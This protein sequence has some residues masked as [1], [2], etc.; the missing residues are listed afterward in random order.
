MNGVI[1]GALM[2]LSMVQ[3][4]TDTV[5]PVKDAKTLAVSTDG[6]SIV[7]TGWDRS[8]VRVQASH[9]LRTNVTVTRSHGGERIDVEAAARRGP[10]GIVDYQISVP[11]TLG[12][13]LDG[14]YTDISVDGVSGSVDAETL[15]GDVTIK[16]G[17]GSVKASTT[18][19]KLLVQGAQGKIDAE[20]AA[21]EIRFLDVVGDVVAESAGGDI[22]FENAKAASVDVGT[23]GGRIR[24]DGS[25][26]KTGTYLFGSYGGPVTLVLPEGTAASMSLS[27][28][29]GSVLNNFSG[30][31]ERL[32]GGERHKVDL[33]GGGAVVEVE[34]FGG[35]IAIVKKGTEGTVG[36]GEDEELRGLDDWVSVVAADQA[37]R[38]AGFGATLGEEL[39]ERIRVHLDHHLAPD[40]RWRPRVGRDTVPATIPR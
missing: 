8:D 29:H 7:V 20:T 31:M 14:M 33:N 27:T 2:A 17:G 6:G 11:R 10:G 39:G 21:G 30:Q 25:M 28:I 12:L 3:Q 19:G 22:L 18:T 13:S 5:I 16:G 9:S 34:T 15:Q 26:T 38:W 24:Y 1:V 40:I 35:R 32:K 4:Q 23:T 36:G 37:E